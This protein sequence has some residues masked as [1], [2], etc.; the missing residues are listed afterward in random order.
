M[1]VLGTDAA[2]RVVGN[3]DGYPDAPFPNSNLHI[4]KTFIVRDGCVLKNPANCETMMVE[5]KTVQKKWF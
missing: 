4:Q 1:Y 3:L 2:R 5:V